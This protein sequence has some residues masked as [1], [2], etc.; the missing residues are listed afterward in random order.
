M[1][2][3]LIATDLNG[4]LLHNDQ[5]FNQDLFKE[6]LQALDQRGIQ[7]VLSSGNQFAHLKQL[8]KDVMADNLTIVA[9]NGASIYLKGK[10][11]FDGSLSAEQVHQFVTVDRQQAALANAYLILVGQNGSYT[12]TGAPQVL[13]D[14][15]AKFYDNLQQVDDLATVTDRI[16]KISVSTSPGQAAELVTA[17]N[18]HFNS[19]LRAHDSGYG[20]VDVVGANV[21]KLPAVQWLARH[22]NVIADDIMAFGDGDNDLPLISYAGQGWAM[23]N[24]PARIREAATQTTSLDNEHDGVLRTIQAVLLADDLTR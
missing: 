3:K 8:F 21:G 2:T 4:T 6:T 15:A 5:S 22:F 20:V 7:L 18:T 17:L 16:K 13:L 11:V 19:R 23:A 9:E 12:E 10:Q 14:A 1:G 24:A